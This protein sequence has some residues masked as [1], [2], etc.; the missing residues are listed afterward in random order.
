[1]ITIKLSPVRN[2]NT[3]LV[4]SWEAPVL[5]VNG[6]LFD[7]S[8]LNDGDEAQHKVL[9]AVSRDGD[10]Y[11]VTLVLPHGA[12]APYKMRF[13]DVINML[14]DGEVPIPKVNNFNEVV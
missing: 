4:A 11:S 5:T 6:D 1:M 13:P 8:E 7:L 2:N 12:N 9:L 14:A 3:P 10:D